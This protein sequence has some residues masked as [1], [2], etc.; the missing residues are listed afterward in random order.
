MAAAVEDDAVM[1]KDVR[2]VPSSSRPKLCATFLTI[3]NRGVAR[4]KRILGPSA[5]TLARRQS[6]HRARVFLFTRRTS[7][8]PGDAISFDDGAVVQFAHPGIFQKL[9]HLSVQVGKRERKTSR[10]GLC[11]N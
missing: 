6:G 1:A 7:S 10:F 2:N 9:K 5:S 3:D 8:R 11:E 4:F